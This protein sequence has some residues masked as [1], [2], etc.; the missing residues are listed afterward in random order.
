MPHLFS[1]HLRNLAI[2]LTLLLP[3]LS[4]AEQPNIVLI[5]TDDLGWGDLGVFY[6]NESKHDKKHRTPQLDQ[7]A[8]GGLQMR[9][10][11]CPA[12]V[13]A[14]SRSSLL[15]GVH[16]GNA[17]VRNNQFD[18]ELEDNHT[19]GS[20]LQEAGYRTCMIGKYGLQGGPKEKQQTGTPDDWPSYPTKRGFDEFFGYVSHYAGHL[21]YPNDPWELANDAHRG[22]PDLWHS[23]ESGDHEISE[24][25]S[26]CYTTDL[27]TARAKHFLKSHIAHRSGQPFFLM[28][29]YD[30][31]HAALQIPT[32]AYPG[33]S[34]ISGGL[35]WTGGTIPGS[36]NE[37]AINTAAGQVD[38]FL[39]PDYATQEWSDLEKRFATMVRR[40]DSAV[41]DLNQ[42][43]VDLGIA[44]NT[45][46]VFTND[47]GPHHEAYLQGESW[48]S[49]SYTP[50]AF[51]SYGPFDGTKRDC[52]EGGI[53]MPTLAWWK[54][55]ISA[56]GINTT[57]SQFHDWMATFCDVAGIPA[58]AR[59]DGVSLLPTLTGKG[60]QQESLVYIEY[61]NG[62]K[63]P[64]YEDFMG[65]RRKRARKEMQVI[66]LT[67]ED[68]KSY[69]GVRYNIKSADDDFEIYDVATDFDE[70]INL[71]GSSSA[72]ES[73]QIRMKAKVLQ[74]RSPN[75]SAVRPYDDT[76]V[77]AT[78]IAQTGFR[79][80]QVALPQHVSYVP[81]VIGEADQVSD[82]IAIKAEDEQVFVA[83][84]PGVY[85]IHGYISMDEAASKQIKVQSESACFMRLHESH[86]IDLQN[87]GEAASSTR[88]LAAGQ[89]PFTLT[90]RA[91][92]EG[93]TTTW[94][95]H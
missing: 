66:R 59:C 18:K 9:A 73:L 1:C 23:D 68:G 35:T 95:I 26:K 64:D 53:R 37:P 92:D 87:G 52:W 47:N 50:Q 76:L 15:T 86:A 84:S 10:H 65:S 45:L 79:V 43:L 83:P 36:I 91:E 90:I 14:P 55:T 34:G 4:E 44:H 11:Y 6:Q 22:V 3:S 71:A 16:Q 27:F 21:H 5:F 67:G 24:S 2:V 51:Q 48:E 89:H 39:H 88:H 70:A 61:Q 94:S 20:V 28:L 19:L 93:D 62:G 38:S 25:L 17:T 82:R 57:P 80:E 42:T 8:A 60:E 29:N 78:S 41:G 7:L 40:I 33:G 31:P 56:G 13:C 54:D 49:T 69:K 30:T 74:V 63:T 58:P 72:M 46:V 81:A 12:P 32:S 75:E 85:Q 77:P